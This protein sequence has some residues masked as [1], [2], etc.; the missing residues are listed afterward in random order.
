MTAADLVRL[1]RN[2]F[3]R[4]FDA[5][6][7]PLHGERVMVL[8]LGSYAAAWTLYATIA[9][10]SQDIHP[11]MAEMAAWSRRMSLGTPKHP[12]LGS[13]LLHAWFS[14]F[15]RADWS[16]YLF[17][18][19]LPAIALWI[20]WRI[21]E[22][23]LPRDKR[24]IGL[25]LL[26]L[27]PFYNFHALKFNANAVLTP[28]WAAT[29]WWF[30]LSF[31]TRRVG[32][33]VLAGIGGAAAVLGKY[34]S[35]ILLA[36]LGFSALTDRRSDNYF[37]SPAPYVSLAVGT[38][39]STPHINWMIA[40]QFA[41]L[42]YAFEAH[43]ASYLTAAESALDFVGSSLA[44][45]AAP[46]AF[47]LIAA[48]PSMAAIADTLWPP[49]PER[50][51]VVEVF[52]MPFLLAVV[53]ALLFKIHIEA[54]WAISMMTLLPVV[55]FSSPLV[56]LP[57]GAGIIATAVAIVF[58]LVMVVVSPVVAVVVHRAGVDNYQDQYQL[59]ARALE[60]SWQKQTGAPLQIVGSVSS[61]VNGAAFYVPSRP[62][63]FDLYSPALTPWVD[64]ES[65]RR[66]GMAMI[67]PESMYA[68][69]R[70]LEG[71][72]AH[73]HATATEHVVLARSYLGEEGVPVAY[74]IVIIPPRGQ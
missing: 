8:M 34:W 65:I 69:M 45:I 59:V 31:E 10:S 15:P 51:F 46:V 26:T 12:P 42:T 73:Y 40:S 19:I 5:L 3:E 20:A 22:R 74:E 1:T 30:L 52:A 60:G 4:V 38:I 57:R 36:A 16:Y 67:C 32:W 27:V 9:K 66:D 58:P 21:S 55:L 29:T 33:A 71:Y 28:F 24:V 7:D 43:P 50:R 61:V 54:L 62:A 25:A 70:M 39:L 72:G 14:L 6:V 44:Y 47:S 13:W 56:T 64:D 49:E 53:V 41:P 37:R 35:A 48:Q 63:T 11:D 2:R 17:A 18:M 68:C 23:Y